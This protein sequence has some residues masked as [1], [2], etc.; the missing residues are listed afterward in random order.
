MTLATADRSFLPAPRP[1]PRQEVMNRLPLE[2]LHLDLGI[3]GEPLP[4][5]L[6]QLILEL[7]QLAPLG[8]QEVSA[9]RFTEELQ[10][11]LTDHA[12]VHDPDAPGLA[13]LGFDL[14]DDGLDGLEVL[15]VAGK[16][17]VCQREAIS[18]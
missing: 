12:A 8:S 18:S 4:V 3:L 13:E 2:E 15:G 17:A 6:S 7:C 16:R 9:V 11:L 1:A 14:A 5:G 10:R